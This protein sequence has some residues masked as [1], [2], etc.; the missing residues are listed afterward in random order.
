MK[1]V[2]GFHLVVE[3]NLVR[4]K[5]CLA[6][7]EIVLALEKGSYSVDWKNQKMVEETDH[8]EKNYDFHSSLQAPLI[9]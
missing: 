4:Q 7:W 2:Q 8:C 6:D 5:G 1:T 9:R 3:M